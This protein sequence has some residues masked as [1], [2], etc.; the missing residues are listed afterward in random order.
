LA[1]PVPDEVFQPFDTVVSV[2]REF[3]LPNNPSNAVVLYQLEEDFG[4]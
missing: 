2:V 4:R 3:P 1:E